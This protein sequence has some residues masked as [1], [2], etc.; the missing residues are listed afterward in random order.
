MNNKTAKHLRRL[1]VAKEPILLMTVRQEYGN[2]TEQMGFRQI[3]QAAKKL[4][5]KGELD[6]LVKA[7]RGIRNLSALRRG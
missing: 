6:D 1:V 3:Y 2:R 7:T 4:Y 5:K